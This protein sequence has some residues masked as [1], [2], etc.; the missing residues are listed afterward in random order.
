MS[1]REGGRGRGREKRGEREKKGGGGE[2]RVGV[3]GSKGGI[4]TSLVSHVA[5]V[6]LMCC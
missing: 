6:L 2:R 4:V 3:R 5:N 1:E